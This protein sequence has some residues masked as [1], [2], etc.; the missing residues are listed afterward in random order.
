MA[1]ILLAA[2]APLRAA[3]LEAPVLQQSTIHVV[4]AGEN[5]F[6]ISLRYNTT[7][8][9]IMAANGLTS[10]YIYVGQELMIPGAGDAAPAEPAPTEP[11]GAAPAAGDY[12]VKAG[13]TLSS[14]AVRYGVSVWALIQAN[15][16]TS[17]SLIYVGQ[18]LAIPGMEGPSPNIVPNISGGESYVVR[19]GD[20][21]TAI[22]QRFGTTVVV[23]ANLNGISNP[24]AI[25]VGQTLKLSGTPPPVPAGAGKRILVDLSDQHLYA[26]QGDQLVYSFI[27]STGAAPYYTR[28]GQFQIQSKIPN[29]Y[30]ST[31][32]IWM[33]HWLGIYYAGSTENGIHALPVLSNGQVLWAG[34]LG[35]PISYGCVVLGTYE[36]ELLYTWA[37]LGT[38]VLI[39]Y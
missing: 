31:W 20:T 24:S 18:S 10:I 1:L 15:G 22:A 9:A 27:A 2:G 21:L 6:R 32:N 7:V 8:D 23:L 34:Y 12:V 19:A 13:D 25:Y 16:L 36:A 33:P 28:A 30:G 35:T 17:W 3:P 26:Y 4:Q 39:Q 29:A 11:S 38:P 14:I 5:L 37:D